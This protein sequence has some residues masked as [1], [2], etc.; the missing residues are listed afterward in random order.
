MEASYPRPIKPLLVWRDYSCQKRE[1]IVETHRLE[2]CMM[3]GQGENPMTSNYLQQQERFRLMGGHAFCVLMLSVS[4]PA[5]GQNVVAWGSDAFGQ[6][7][8]PLSATNAVSVACGYT[9]SLAL[10]ADGTVMGWGSNGFGE[11]G[12][13]CTRTRPRLRSL[14]ETEHR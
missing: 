7:D 2:T 1:Y 11:A 9:H 8:V 4:V 14:P 13:A 5:F 3:N 10:R 6:I 12:Y